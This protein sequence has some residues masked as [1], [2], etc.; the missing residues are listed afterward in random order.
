M[1]CSARNSRQSVFW[2]EYLFPPS[3]K[4]VLRRVIWNVVDVLLQNFFEFVRVKKMVKSYSHKPCGAVL[5]GCRDRN[6][7]LR[8]QNIFCGGL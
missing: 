1:F 3:L 2:E 4:F 7:Y 6:D 5:L 8:N